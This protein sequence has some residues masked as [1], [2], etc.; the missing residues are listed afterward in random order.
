M[1]LEM[2]G[3]NH[4]TSSIEVREKAVFGQERLDCVLASINLDENIKGIAILST[5]N[6][7]ELY[8]SPLEHQSEEQLRQL[9]VK[10]AG[11]DELEVTDAY[12]LRDTDVVLHIFRV[13][14]GLDSQ[15]LGEKQ[16]LGQV[17]QAYLRA[18]T[19]KTTN[20]ILNRLFI[21]AI[22]CGKQVRTNTEISSGAVS[23]ASVTVQLANK[24][25]GSLD[26]C[27][28]L[29]IGTGDTARLAARH[30]SSAGVTKW[31][32][33]N[34]TL[35]N[36]QDLA[37]MLH[38]DVTSFPPHPDDISWADFIV[39]ATS[40][41]EPIITYETVKQAQKHRQNNL[42]ILDLAVP[43]DVEAGVEQ[44][45]DLYI[46]TIDDFRELVASNLEARQREAIHAEK[47]IQRLA[48]DFVEWY[49]KNRIAPMI[50]QIQS[51]LE[52]IRL[53]QL[54]KVYGR[55]DKSDH[56]KLDAFSRSLIKKVVSLIIANIKKA[57]ND[58][59]EI[60]LAKA[61]SVA[62]ASDKSDQTK[63]LLEI[64]DYELSH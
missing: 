63:Y 10:H 3:I 51:I 6:R 26:E 52:Q 31:R 7:T 46:Y 42:L 17:K 60:E 12:M 16:I 44:L 57:N 37:Q 29:L 59:T 58:V 36:A 32:V 53:E 34:R 9:F 48:S 41:Q 35:Q 2:I 54:E 64:L 55:F 27:N 13:A 14:S 24:I 21:K 8:L 19:Q 1:K 30:L 62:L 33:S 43:R 23:V 22:E 5:C 20:K 39:T 38:G 49:Q 28:V 4:K 15:I 45:P 50:E 11:I 25:F 47:I 56:Q 18:L 40:A 61:V